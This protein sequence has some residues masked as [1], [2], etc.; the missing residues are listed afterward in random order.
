MGDAAV[1]GG[2]GRD[3]CKGHA[4]GAWTRDLL[5]VCNG[6]AWGEHRDGLGL[7]T[8]A[9]EDNPSRKRRHTQRTRF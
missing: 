1:L 9:E 3:R 2:E 8:C 4:G 7:L 5:R 6:A